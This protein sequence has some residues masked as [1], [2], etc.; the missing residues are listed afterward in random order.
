[1]LE[2]IKLII[3]RAPPQKVSA[4]RDG[5]SLLCVNYP[6]GPETGS[7][8]SITTPTTVAVA[9]GV[10]A[11]KRVDFAPPP[12][13]PPPPPLPILLTSNSLPTSK[14]RSTAD[15]FYQR[16]YHTNSN[17]KNANANTN[18]T[19][20]A[21]DEKGYY[22]RPYRNLRNHNNGDFTVIK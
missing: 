11:R 17:G 14:I 9:A 22:L 15:T 21:V 2:L 5:H 1:M 10:A 8:S 6:E 3:S 13:P 12:P 7:S 20:N 19:N 18:I 4:N 16:L